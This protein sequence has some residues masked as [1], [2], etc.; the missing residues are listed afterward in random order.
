MRAT[1]RIVKYIKDYYLYF[2]DA[3]YEH[4]VRCRH[5]CQHL[6]SGARSA[7]SDHVRPEN[8]DGQ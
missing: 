1:F 3:W 5:D 6:H 8:R 2:R 7:V 4:I